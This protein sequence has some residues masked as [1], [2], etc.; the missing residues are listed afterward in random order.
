M[1]GTKHRILVPV[2]RP[3]EWPY[4]FA[5]IEV[6]QPVKI[7]PEPENPYDKNALCIHDAEGLQM[8][9]V[10]KELAA[11]LTPGL[12][13]QA[14]TITESQVSE[15]ERSDSWVSVFVEITLEVLQ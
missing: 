4:D 5:Q 10:P 3:R 2:R 13:N 12:L 6:G 8:G 14:V 7:V 9:Y 15:I 1:I 11:K